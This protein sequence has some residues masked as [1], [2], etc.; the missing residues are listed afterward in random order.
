MRADQLLPSPRRRG[1]LRAVVAGS[2]VAASVLL[3]TTVA[4]ADEPTGGTVVG[5]L[6]QAWAEAAPGDHE[7]RGEHGDDGLTSWVRTAEGDTIA[8]PSSDV[9]GVPSG[10]TVQV[11]TDGDGSAGAAPEGSDVEVLEL[12]A[13]PVLTRTAGV[14]NRVTVALV[15]PGGVAGDATP[16]QRLVDVVDGPVAQ[17]WAEQSDGAIQVGVT[18]AAPGW[19]TTAASCAS[20]SVLWDEVAAKVGFVPGPGNHLLLYVSPA[21][22]GC[23]Y[24][25]AEV[26]AGPG[27]G[28]RMYVRDVGTSVIAHELGHN[29]GLG[30]SSGRQCD[31]AVESDSCRTVSYRDYYDVM[32]VSWAQLGSLT[33]PQAARLG[34]L[35]PAARQLVST[36]DAPVTVTLAPV[37]GRSGTRAVRLTD[38][39]GA[40]YWLEYRP[41]AG[42]D[43]WLGT[44]T[45]LYGLDAGVLLRRSGGLPDTSVLLDGTPTGSAGWDADRQAALPTGTAVPVSGGDFTVVVD[46]AGPDWAVVTV[47]PVG[48]PAAAT[49]P[50]PSPVDAA[51]PPAVLPGSDAP[52]VAQEST[53]RLPVLSAQAALAAPLLDPASDAGVPTGVVVVLAAALLGGAT[54][55]VVRVLRRGAFSR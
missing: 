9:E 26:G 52:A 22:P 46:S 27:S 48:G 3:P 37:S 14:S 36:A 11:T 30:H 10:A 16:V 4:A 53:P 13:A 33:A 49:A 39:E 51:S 15:A 5:E 19:V 21:A 18:A 43:A 45:N 12:P 34:V 2:A 29:F 1:L 23:A 55:L 8:V 42:R 28:G 35:P 17:F 50:V 31:A 44:S 38:A 6:V 7:E 32:G 41:A 47:T 40:E 20:P 54:V 25:L 24:A